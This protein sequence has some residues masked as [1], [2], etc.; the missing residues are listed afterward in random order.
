M[1]ANITVTLKIRHDTADNWRDRNPVL[2]LGEYGLEEDTFL[3][4]IGDGTSQWNN[5]RY[6]N[7]LDSEYFTYT[8][9]GELTFSSSFNEVLSEIIEKQSSTEQLTI[10]NA[11]VEG[12]DAA[13]KQYVDEAIA[14]VG[15][16]K[17]EIVVGPIS[18]VVNPDEDTIYLVQSGSHYIEYY[19]INNQLTPI[20]AAGGSSSGALMPATSSELGGVLSSNADN[21][22]AV[23]VEGFMT[24][25]RVSTS[26]LYVPDGDTLT[27]DGG[28]A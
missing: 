1:A 14:A 16:L 24:L 26:L 11:P 19:L 22:I 27:L 15:H 18:N 20:G 4:K 21:Q 7:K 13:N 10:T 6:L 8:A 9:N 2:Q 23:T 28:N 25:N 12:T 5:L 3:I 17:K